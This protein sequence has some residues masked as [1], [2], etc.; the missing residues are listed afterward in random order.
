MTKDDISKTVKRFILDEFLPG[1]SP[2]ALEGTTPLIS[3]GIIDSIGTIKLVNFLEET[4]SI[5]FKAHEFKDNLDTIES[6]VG[7]VEKKASP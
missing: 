6:I 1:E 4:Y 5:K 7:I 3:G 2:S